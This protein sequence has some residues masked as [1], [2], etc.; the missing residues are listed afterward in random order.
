MQAA[1]AQRIVTEV[2][3]KLGPHQG[4]SRTAIWFFM[5]QMIVHTHYRIYPGVPRALLHETTDIRSHRWNVQ[6]DNAVQSER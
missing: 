5:G 3:S 1:I 2:W 6:P 4:S